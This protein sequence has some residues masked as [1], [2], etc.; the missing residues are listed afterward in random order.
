MCLEASIERLEALVEPITHS[1]DYITNQN[2]GSNIR[3]ARTVS[4]K[5][6]EIELRQ[7]NQ[8][9]IKN[10]RYEHGAL[11]RKGFLLETEEIYVT[12]IGIL[13]KQ[14]ERIKA[15]ENSN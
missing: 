13:K 8:N 9:I 4:T 5:Q 14:D 12:L 1:L 2:R 7:Y 10:P 6:Y 3:D 15:L 11:P